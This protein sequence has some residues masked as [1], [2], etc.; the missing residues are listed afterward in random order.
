MRWFRAALVATLVV[1]ACAHAP[2]TTVTAAPASFV[3]QTAIRVEPDSIVVARLIDEGMRRSH[4]AADLEYLSDVIGPRLAGSPEMVRANQWTQQKFHDYGMDSTS[5][6]GFAFGVPWIRGPATA[7]ML[8][9]QRRELIAVSWAWAPST[10]GPLSGDVVLVDSRTQADFD[11]RFAGKLRDKWVMIGPAYALANPDGPHS[12]ADSIRV[13]SLRR[14]AAAHTDEERKFMPSRAALL[15]NEQIAGVIRDGA[16]EFG[17]LTMSGSPSAISLY[18]QVVISN[19]NYAQFE[20]LLRGG[21][22]VRFQADVKNTFGPRPVQQYNTVGEIRGSEKPD[23]IVLV[24]AHLDSWDLATGATDNGAGAVAVLE[25]ARI[26]ASAGE[27]PKRTIRF[28]LFG[29]EEEGLFGSQAYAAAHRSE[30]DSYQAVLVLD[31]GSGR[32]TGM[33][34]QNRNDLHD[35]WATMM[36]PLASLG[37]LYARPGVK[38]GTDHLS[39]LPYGVPAFNYDQLSRGYEHTHHSQVDDFDHVVPSDVAQAA[40]VMAV[41]AW[42]LAELPALLPRGPKT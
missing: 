38:T 6:E 28:V 18:P 5:L 16:K 15:A 7:R 22:Q 11:R 21:E 23:E 36:Q 34:L 9:P 31:N 27:R 42:Q 10:N 24:G 8:A 4:A 25:A 29:A 19:E 14:S 3:S 2:Q 30:L 26:L 12:A 13:D 41:N 35:M 39:F 37:S 40:T 1:A 33:E 17:L 20:R 32:I